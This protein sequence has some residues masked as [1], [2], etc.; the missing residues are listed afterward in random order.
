MSS[1]EFDYKNRVDD[2]VTNCTLQIRLAFTTS[3]LS[4]PAV[5]R[6][7]KHLINA[8]IQ[9]FASPEF[10]NHL[11]KASLSQCVQELLVR[12]LD[13]KLTLVDNGASISKAL[14]V[15]MVR[16]LENSNRNDSFR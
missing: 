2:L 1:P 5:L 14:N 8:L 12:L 15:L 6:L 13:P 4:D 9:V 16:I 11:G 7:C 3:D 10:S